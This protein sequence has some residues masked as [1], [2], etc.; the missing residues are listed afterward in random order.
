MPSQFHYDVFL[1][2]SSKDKA[3]VRPL[4]ERLRNRRAA[5]SQ[6]GRKDER[7]LE[8]EFQ[9]LAF[10]LQ[11]LLRTFRFRDPLNKA[12]R[13]IPLRLDDAPVAGKRPMPQ[14]KG[15]GYGQ[16]RCNTT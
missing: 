10:N 4:A 12:R 1:S 2:H 15:S 9:R 3:A 7:H 16:E 5:V 6:R 13:L 14:R 8:A 11:P